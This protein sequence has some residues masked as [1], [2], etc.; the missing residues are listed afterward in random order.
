MYMHVM[1]LMEELMLLYGQHLD[2]DEGYRTTMF[3][4]CVVY[5]I[6]MLI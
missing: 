4:F 5:A 1:S 3:W 2:F 6:M